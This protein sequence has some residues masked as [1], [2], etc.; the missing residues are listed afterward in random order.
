MNVIPGFG[1]ARGDGPAALDVAQIERY[2]GIDVGAETIKLV[3]VLRQGAELRIGIR[4][5]AEHH[6]EPA[7]CLLDMLGESDWPCLS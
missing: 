4:R 6:K 1:G 2:L 5:L 3:E 7:R